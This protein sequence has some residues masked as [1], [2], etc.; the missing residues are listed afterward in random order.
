MT[1]P[2]F[3]TN[4]LATRLIRKAEMTAIASLEGM[5]AT[6]K[7][8]AELAH[9]IKRAIIAQ[10]MVG[11]WRE[12]DVHEVDDVSALVVT[13]S[14]NKRLVGKPIRLTYD[15]KRTKLKLLLVEPEKPET[16]S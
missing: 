12:L 16:R 6:P 10:V 5:K 7:A 3:D 11:Q 15:W 14:M 4:A 13:A 8:L 1:P 2:R 9:R